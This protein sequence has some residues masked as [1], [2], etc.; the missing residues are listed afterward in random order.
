MKLKI[1]NF[2]ISRV[3]S[4]RQLRHMIFLHVKTVI[5]SRSDAANRVNLCLS[6]VKRHIVEY[7]HIFNEKNEVVDKQYSLTDMIRNSDAQ[8]FCVNSFS[9]S[10]RSR[11]IYLYFRTT[12]N[13]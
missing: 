10:S 4:N 7:H 6:V 3:L 11:Y 13:C 9:S 8:Q 1:L 12:G 5:Q 2:R